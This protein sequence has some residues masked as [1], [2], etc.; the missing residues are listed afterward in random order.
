MKVIY[1]RENRM[2]RV[3]RHR[4]KKN[5]STVCDFNDE[6]LHDNITCRPCHYCGKTDLMGADRIDNKKGH[7]KDNIVPCCKQCNLIKNQYF[8]CQEFKLLVDYCRKNGIASKYF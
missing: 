7:T 6:W 8:N 4:D 3:Y 2:V 5:S 1:V